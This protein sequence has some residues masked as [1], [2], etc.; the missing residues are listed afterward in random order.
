MTDEEFADAINRDSD[1][2]ICGELNDEE[3][4]QQVK[5]QR[6]GETSE[7]QED[8]DDEFV[9]LVS[10]KD[11]HTAMTTIRLYLQQNALE[12]IRLQFQNTEEALA[13]TFETQR[14]QKSITDFLKTRQ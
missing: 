2:Q 7:E 11:L 10:R 13:S 9:Q 8:D 14:V 4:V 12:N 5:R 6:T 3:I 1:E